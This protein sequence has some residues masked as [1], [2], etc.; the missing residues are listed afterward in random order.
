M[1]A[2]CCGKMYFM[3]SFAKREACRAHDTAGAQIRSCWEKGETRG[4]EDDGQLWE[5][6]E[7]EEL[8]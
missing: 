8:G 4:A 2:S 6:R 5:T 7:E 3:E 1:A